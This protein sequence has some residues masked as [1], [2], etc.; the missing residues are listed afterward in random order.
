MRGFSI[1]ITTVWITATMQSWVREWLDLGRRYMKCCAI[2][3]AH[4][5]EV[6]STGGN[7]LEPAR[8]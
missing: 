6:G 2:A 1:G 3:A 5:S 7:G 8:G 4:S